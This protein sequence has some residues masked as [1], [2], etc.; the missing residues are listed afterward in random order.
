MLRVLAMKLESCRLLS[1]AWTMLSQD[2]EALLDGNDM[3]LSMMAC[4]Q[5]MSGSPPDRNEGASDSQVFPMLSVIPADLECAIPWA[6]VFD[7]HVYGMDASLHVR[8]KT[9]TLGS[10]HVW[11]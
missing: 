3:M 1:T 7:K 11:S 4:T 10:F 6:N 8:V 2:T 5:S 9:S